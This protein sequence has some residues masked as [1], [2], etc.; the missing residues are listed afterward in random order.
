MKYLLIKIKSFFSASQ[1]ID[2]ITYLSYGN[3]SAVRVLGR[4][5]KKNPI[6]NFSL[7]QSRKKH[8]VDVIKLFSTKKRAHV[9]LTYFKGVQEGLFNSN[10]QGHFSHIID[11]HDNPQLELKLN[12]KKVPIEFIRPTSKTKKL[13]ISDI[14]DTIIK[15]RATS[16]TSLVL[17]VLFYPLAKREAFQEA[18]AFYH[19]LQKGEN[20]QQENL[21]MYLSSSTW[22]LYPM[23][24]SFIKEN[25]F[26]IGPLLLQ[27]IKS[28]KKKK[29]AKRHQHKIDRIVELIEFYPDLKL[30]LIGDAG[31][32]DAAIYLE[33]AK[34]F[35]N[36]I[37]F[38]LIRYT[39]W[40]KKQG[41]YTDYLAK[42]SELGVKMIYFHNLNEV[43][44]EILV[45]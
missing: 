2:V 1:S 36:K 45:T 19:Q 26:P 16:M 22:T 24:L 12:N 10:D 31:Q 5:V 3:N 28:E 39:W 20:Q 37:D 17:K 18:A 42:A 8:F 4:V 6:T 43:P 13:I 9:P 14:D 27:N 34:K 32:R 25:N 7:M 23:L 29:G 38:I 21:I 40:T 30:Q 15:S 33:I 44:K 11:I 41:D 35:P